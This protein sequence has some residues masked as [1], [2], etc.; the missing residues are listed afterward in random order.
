MHPTAV[1]AALDAYPDGLC[2]AAL[3]VYVRARGLHSFDTVADDALLA[4]ILD[5]RH[6]TGLACLAARGATQADP[7]QADP[8]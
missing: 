8:E 3:A 5:H 7:D 1:I 6:R 4:G 2:Y